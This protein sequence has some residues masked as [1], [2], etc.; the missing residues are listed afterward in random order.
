MFQWL[1][2]KLVS[3]V[4]T[5]VFAFASA[6]RQLRARYDAAITNAENRRHWANVDGLSADAAANPSV[7]RIIRWRTRYEVANNSWAKGIVQTL[8]NYVVGTGPRLQMLTQD[9]DLNNFIEREFLRWAK[10][11]RLAAKLRTLRMCRSVDGEGFLVETINPQLPTPVKFDLRAVEADQVTT[12]D[13]SLVDPGRVDGIEFDEHGN[14]AFYHILKFHPGDFRGVGTLD[15][16]RV[17]ADK[18][19]HYFRA[20]RPGQSRGLPELM[21]A[22]ELFGQLRRYSQAV[23]GAAET[24]ADFAGFIQTNAQPGEIEPAKELPELEIE[25][26]MLVPLPEGW[27]AYQMKAEQPTTTHDVFVRGKLNEI[28]RCLNMPLNI[29][30]ANSAGYN[31]ASGRLDHQQFFVAV[32]VD[33][34]DLEIGPVERIFARWLREAVLIEDYLPPAARTLDFDP[35][36]QWFWTG[37]EHVDPLKE[38]SAQDT[39]LRNGATSYAREYAKVGLDWEKEQEKQAAAFGISVEEYRKRLRDNMLAVQQP[40]AAEDPEMEEADA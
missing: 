30:M 8:A 38:A 27:E 7:R 1:R 29:A 23:L 15:Y 2:K 5:T 22:I 13:L 25:R 3:R 14:P 21:P 9:K 18:V 24:A 39:R 20:D 34:D 35:D 26:R 4:A 16:D 17:P 12:P 19:I 11:V 37:P 28:A 10:A 40:T 33:Q 36:H 31:Y 32:D 6:Y